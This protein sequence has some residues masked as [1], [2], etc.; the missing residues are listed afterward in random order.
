VSDTVKEAVG[1]VL[2]ARKVEELLLD[3]AGRL[4]P[5]QRLQV[6][7]SLAARPGNTVEKQRHLDIWSNT[8]DMAREESGNDS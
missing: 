3:L 2:A 6:T 7:S 8:C 1:A 4:E 5:H